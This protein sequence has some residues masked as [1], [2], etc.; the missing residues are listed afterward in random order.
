M[1]SDPIALFGPEMLADPYPTYRRLR[2]A[3]PVYWRPDLGCWLL[4]RYDDVAAVFHDPRCS[5]AKVADME[6]R[7]GDPALHPLFATFARFLAYTD[8]PQHTRIRGLVAKA[9]TP[10]VVEAMRG[11]VETV[12]N[13]LLDRV[14]GPGR[15]DVIRDLAD[16]LP[17][18]VIGEILGI[19]PD[20]RE[21]FK[22]L[23]ENEHQAFKSVSARITP[24]DY[25]LARDSVMEVDRLFRALV[26]ERRR[27]PGHDL[28]SLLLAASEGGDRLREDELVASA[29]FLLVA[30]ND[31]AT[32]LIGNAVLALLQHPDELRRLRDDPSLVPAALEESMRFNGAVQF[33]TRVAH[34]DLE[35]GGQ[36]IRRGQVIYLLLGAANRDP[37][38][39][40]DPDRFDVTRAPDKHVAFG[41][42]GHYCLGAP[43]ARLQ[44]Q[45]ALRALL[46]R[47]PGLRLAGGT[48]RYR[49]NFMLRGLQALPVVFEKT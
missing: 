20:E 5:S 23:V 48:P 25:R 32:N 43:L 15:M 36:V 26:A 6:A 9:F 12:V 17:S 28:L 4:S 1:S 41:M 38:H 22:R 45:V 42:G 34:E 33:L 31:A 21:R 16:P 49:D 14:A 27:A 8:P 19:P 3:D 44:G 18:L 30:G 39:F 29:I 40:P 35:V 10:Q 2:Q 46:D 47:L 37:A 7:A 13:G 24:K 11:Y